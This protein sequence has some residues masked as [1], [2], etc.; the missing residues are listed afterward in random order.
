MDVDEDEDADMLLSIDGGA[1]GAFG[2]VDLDVAVVVF[3]VPA[4]VFVAAEELV[5]FDDDCLRLF[6][7]VAGFVVLVLV[8]LITTP[9]ACLVVVV[10]VADLDVI[11]F[12]NPIRFSCSFS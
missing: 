1:D 8:V 2:E 10:V 12:I 5:V 6:V 11:E 7:V 9:V 4:L 3:A